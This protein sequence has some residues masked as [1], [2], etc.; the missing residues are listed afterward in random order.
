MIGT[1]TVTRTGTRNQARESRLSFRRSHGVN[2][3]G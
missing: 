1:E 2:L 3:H